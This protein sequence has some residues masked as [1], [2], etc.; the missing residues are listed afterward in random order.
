MAGLEHA[1][2]TSPRTRAGAVMDRIPI[3]SSDFAGDTVDERYFWPHMPRHTPA[4]RIPWESYPP[5]G[6]SVT[7]RGHFSVLKRGQFA[8]RPVGRLLAALVLGLGA[9]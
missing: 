4:A 6:E 9:A 7:W 1:A 8:A 3:C 2:T 5:L